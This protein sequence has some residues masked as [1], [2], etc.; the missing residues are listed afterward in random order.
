MLMQRDHWKKGVDV[1]QY[2]KKKCALKL[3]FYSIEISVLIH[4]IK[5]VC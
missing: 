5:N 2:G 1:N 4:S 3:V